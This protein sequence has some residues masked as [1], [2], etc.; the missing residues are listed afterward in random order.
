MFH[1][2]SKLFFSYSVMYSLDQPTNAN[3]SYIPQCDLQSY[4]TI[5]RELFI[6]IYELDQE[7]QVSATSKL[8]RKLQI[9]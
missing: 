1:I 7:M 8:D 3:T 2:Y 5:V 4:K 9:R 6:S